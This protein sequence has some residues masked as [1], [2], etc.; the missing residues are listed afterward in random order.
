MILGSGPAIRKKLFKLAGLHRIDPCENIGKVFLGIDVVALCGCDEREMDGSRLPASIRAG[1]QKILSREYECLHVPFAGIIVYLQIRLFQ[2]ASQGNPVLQVV[3][4]RLSQQVGG[5]KS[6]LS[7]HEFLAQSFDQGFGAFAPNGQSFGRRFAADIRFHLIQPGVYFQN[8]VADL[9][10]LRQGVEYS[11]ASVGIASGLSFGAVLKQSI[12]AVC[13][14]GLNDSV[15]VLQ[16]SLILLERFIGRKVENCEPVVNITAVDSHLALA[17]ISFEFPVL[18][19][20]FRVIGLNYPR[21]KYLPLHEFMQRLDQQGGADHPIRLGGSRNDGL[22]SSEYFLLA[23]VWKAIV[24]LTDN[25]AG[26][27]TGP[28]VTARNGRAGLFGSGNVGLALGTG[29]DL[30]LVLQA[31]E[32]AS[33]LLKLMGDFIG[34]EFGL[35][36]TS[37]ADDVFV[38]DFVRDD[39][40]G[41][42]LR[43]NMFLPNMTTGLVWDGTPK[44]ERTGL[45]LGQGRSWIVPLS[46]VT[47][48]TPI[49][50]LHLGEK[51]IELILEVSELFA[52]F[53]VSFKRFRE[54]LLKLF[55]EPC[56]ILNFRER[57]GVCLSQS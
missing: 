42:I 8:A 1:E 6:A 2:K 9:Y 55:D 24:E 34:D 17:H 7:G 44:P 12:E 57:A 35:H 39:L 40:S 20:N 36:G 56:Q 37:R 13:G 25:D 10:L 3:L 29:A 53:G 11:A 47:K 43:V 18:D 16:K 27:E 22:F 52:Q 49:A 31:L 15:K 23:I 5:V 51:E 21:L 33:Q 26:Q 19:L 45:L 4:S 32:G 54:L 41:Q 50:F 46:L 48:I 28:G 14:I 38:F 30:L